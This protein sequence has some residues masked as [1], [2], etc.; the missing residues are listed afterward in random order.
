MGYS[1]RVHTAAATVG[2]IRPPEVA[3][4]YAP[5]VL[6]VLNKVLLACELNVDCASFKQINMKTNGSG[7]QMGLLGHTG[8]FQCLQLTTLHV[9][10]LWEENRIPRG[11]H[12]NQTE[13]NGQP[14][15][16]ALKPQIDVHY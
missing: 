11:E 10:G 6:K 14:T 8:Q 3:E 12:A 9:F 15:R 5:F 1:S 2:R 7:T 4:F 13:S 16:V